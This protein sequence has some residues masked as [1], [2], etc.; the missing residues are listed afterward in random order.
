VATERA[1]LAGRAAHP[2]SG[3][4]SAPDVAGIYAMLANLPKQTP[5]RRQAYRF[6]ATTHRA[7]DRSSPDCHLRIRRRVIVPFR[8]GGR[9]W[10]RF[11]LRDARGRFR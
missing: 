7:V 10:S 1:R 3:V 6:A 4:V 11:Q 9:H 2:G 5:E 8:D